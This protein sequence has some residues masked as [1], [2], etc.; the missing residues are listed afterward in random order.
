[1]PKNKNKI[2]IIAPHPD[3]EVLG[4]GGTIKKYS[5][6][7]SE[8]SL[9]IVTKGY[10]PDWSE[11]FQKNIKKST[12]A[13]NKILGIKKTYYLDFPTA[14]LD[15][16][17]QKEINDSILKCVEEVNPDEVFIPFS[18]DASKDH[19]LIFESFLVAAR[20]KPGLAIKRILSYEVLSETEWGSQ[21]TEKGFLPNVYMDISET[22][23]QKIEAIQCYKSELKEIPHPRSLE[24]IRALAEKRGSEAGLDAAEAFVL[25]RQIL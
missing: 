10:S 5:S 25:V 4:C 12:E 16:I 6:Q 3:D 23:K 7:G 1:M 15:T 13:S 9:C 22:L 20:P 14:K 11:E 21:I 8:I 24:I 17:A 19:R 18:G 2:L